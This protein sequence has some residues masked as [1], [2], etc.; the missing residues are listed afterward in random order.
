MVQ[1]LQRK[2]P[3]LRYYELLQYLYLLFIIYFL[4]HINTAECI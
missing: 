2:F 3:D 4:S 1:L